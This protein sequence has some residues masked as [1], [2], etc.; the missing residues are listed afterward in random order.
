MTKPLLQ[1]GRNLSE[2]RIAAHECIASG[3][4]PNKSKQVVGWYGMFH[5]ERL[6]QEI[7]PKL[8]EYVRKGASYPFLITSYRL[9]SKTDAWIEKPG[10]RGQVRDVKFRPRRRREAAQ[11]EA[12]VYSETRYELL[13][14]NP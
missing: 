14:A 7:M 4:T 6:K 2:H 13:R 9:E 3:S 12:V 10:K 11:K 8:T 1:I 5:E